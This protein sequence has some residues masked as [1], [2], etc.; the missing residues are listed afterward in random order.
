MC[1]IK[2]TDKKK[3]HRQKQTKT[4]K[5]AGLDDWSVVK[6]KS[7]GMRRRKLI[8]LPILHDCNGDLAKQW[9][10]YYSVRNPRTDKMQRFKLY[11]GINRQ[12]TLESRTKAGLLLCNE[13]SEKLK[14]GWSPFL[15]DSEVIYDDQLEYDKISRIYGKKRAANKT[16]RYYASQYVETLIGNIDKEGTLPTYQSKIRIF[17]MWIDKHSNAENDVTAI[18]NNMVV[19]FFR[20]LI[21]DQHRSKKTIGTYRQVLQ[22]LFEWLVKQKVFLNNP[23]HDLPNTNA[24]NDQ[25]P[26]PIHGADIQ[27]FKDALQHDKQ[28]WLAVQFQYYCALRPGK[29]L[30]LLKIKNIEDR[31]SVV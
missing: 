7:K 4:D 8:I 16:I 25:S 31:K 6:L 20:W 12:H 24:I 3:Q 2:K 18:D 21:D 14:R 1:Y 17:C 26:A 13:I 10:V 29:E 11:G 5:F 19:L 27:C 28:L 15:D 23:V 9:F 22:S 30:R